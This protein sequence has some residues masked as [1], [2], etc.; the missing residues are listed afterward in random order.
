MG[1]LYFAGANLCTQF[2]K[3]YLPRLMGALGFPIHLPEGFPSGHTTMAVS[4]ALTLVMLAPRNWRPWMTAIGG[5]GAALVGYSLFR[6]GFHAPV[7]ILAAVLLTFGLALPVMKGLPRAEQGTS[8]GF[9]PRV[10]AL[11]LGSLGLVW[12]LSGF[13][14]FFWLDVRPAEATVALAAYA[15]GWRMATG[16]VLL[17]VSLGALRLTGFRA[18]F[19]RPFLLLPLLL[20]LALGDA[21]CQ[22]I[23]MHARARSPRLAQEA[24]LLRAVWLDRV[25]QKLSGAGDSM[26]WML[27]GRVPRWGYLA[28]LRSRIQ[29]VEK[30]LKDFETRP[31]DGVEREAYLRLLEDWSGFRATLEETAALVKGAPLDPLTRDRASK[32]LERHRTRTEASLAELTKRV[33]SGYCRP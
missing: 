16:S 24:E 11:I 5:A 12:L 6:A 31:M 26:S 32:R 9:Y 19:P 23:Q 14:V 7:D 4:F 8:P 2:I 25:G 13:L 1:V 27:G 10:P 20:S 15:A 22:R 17:A 33:R 18:A 3:E 28:I 21:V 29:S 30:D